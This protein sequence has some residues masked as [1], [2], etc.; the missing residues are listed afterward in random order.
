MRVK[1]NVFV[2][3]ISDLCV[4][5]L[6]GGWFRLFFVLWWIILFVYYYKEFDDFVRFVNIG[7]GSN[8]L[9]IELIIIWWILLDFHFFYYV[10]CF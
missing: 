7:I 5:F 8:L 3:L 6:I 10:V 9:R 1:F 4:C 2:F